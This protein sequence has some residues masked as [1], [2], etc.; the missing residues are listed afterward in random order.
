MIV[1]VFDRPDAVQRFVERNILPPGSP[2]FGAAY[3]IGFA[4]ETE[5]F[6][7]GVV[8]HNWDPPTGVVELSAFATRHD[9]LN[10][11]RLRMIYDYPFDHL[12]CRLAVARHSEHNKEARRIWRALGA[13]ETRLPQ[14][15][16]DDEDEILAALHADT[17]RKSK[18][19]RCS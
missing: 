8:F 2:G 18:F 16:A 9:W 12:G 1:P 19:K 7:A 17:W 15:R 10:R 6:V 4:T 14:M 3:G 5:G 11:D 13:S